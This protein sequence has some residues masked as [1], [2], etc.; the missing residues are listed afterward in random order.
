MRDAMFRGALRRAIR[1]ANA[2]GDDWTSRHRPPVFAIHDPETMTTEPVYG[3]IGYAYLSWPPRRSP[4]GTWLRDNRFDGQYVSVQIPHR[5][6]ARRECELLIACEA[7]AL[8][9]LEK[10]GT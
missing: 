3:A 7:A 9:E 2:A 5:Y 1:S 10:A 8:R 6:M 4:F